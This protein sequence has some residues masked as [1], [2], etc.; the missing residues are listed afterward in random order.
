[1]PD[2]KRSIE[3]EKKV[4]NG[5]R[6]H[7]NPNWPGRG[8]NPKGYTKDMRKNAKL[9]SEVLREIYTGKGGRKKLKKLAAVCIE[10]AEA[11]HAR[12]AEL[13]LDR[14]EGPVKHEPA[15]VTNN[16]IFSEAD[17]QRAISVVDDI[18]AMDKKTITLPQL[19]EEIHGHTSDGTE[20]AGA[21]G[22]E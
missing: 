21:S 4:T 7:G 22:T 19:P 13:I 14:L 18:L 5:L 9:F 11:G 10:Y 12:F 1:M 16:F 20:S 8:G 17:R 6:L 2:Y 15:S 3:G